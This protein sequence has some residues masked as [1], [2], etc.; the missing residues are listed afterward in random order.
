MPREP[1]NP[2]KGNFWTLD[3]LAEDMFDNGSF[4]RRRKRYKRHTVDPHGLAFP[5]AV[6]NPFTSFWVRK[7]VPIFPIQFGAGDISCSANASA[8]MTTGIHDNFDLLA[9]A[10][11][12]IA[13]ASDALKDRLAPSLTDPNLFYA[14]GPANF[15]L[16]RRNI[17]A[18][19]NSAVNNAKEN[20]F[21]LNLNRKQNQSFF[22]RQMIDG[23][24]KNNEKYVKVNEY[25]D[26]K[27]N[28]AY[29]SSD[30]SV[31]KIDVE[32]ED[33]K[34]NHDCHS[35]DTEVSTMQHTN[36]ATDENFLLKF[37]AQHKQ[38]QNLNAEQNELHIDSSEATTNK[39]R[40]DSAF[41]DSDF[42]V[43]RKA[44]AKYF[45]IENLI[46]RS[47]TDDAS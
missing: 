20:D 29:L 10:D 3:P 5:A 30:N 12:G 21:F 38:Q 23:D 43:R 27:S 19:R 22:G 35:S 33:E 15:D 34:T 13:T 4:L 37:Y 40:Y 17:N 18:L 31:E 2:G 41:P 32:F 14:N 26:G 9:T 46:G 39:H 47:V 25:G 45:S 11:G 7:P 42:E 1:G 24:I 44:N 36:T 6:F 8:F 28:S 16:L